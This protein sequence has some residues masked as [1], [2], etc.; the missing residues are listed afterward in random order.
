MSDRPE[1]GR[2][3]DIITDDDWDEVMEAQDTADNTVYEDQE[4][5]DEAN[6]KE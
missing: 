3:S 5:E 6:L 2:L 1:L 4:S